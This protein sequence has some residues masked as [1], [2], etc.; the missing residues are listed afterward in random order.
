MT[1]SLPEDKRI[2]ILEHLRKFFNKQSCKI[3]DFARLIGT[4]NSICRT[5]AYGFVYIR[6]FER[7]KF[8]ACIDSNNDY[9]VRMMLPTSLQ[10]DFRWWLHRLR[11]PPIE[12]PLL[13]R[14]FSHVIFSDASPSG[15]GASMG[16]K[17]T[18]GWWSDQDRDEHINFLELKAVEYAL[19]SFGIDTS[20]FSTHTT[21][22]ASFSAAA[23]RGISIEDIRKTAG[24]S[25][26]SSTFANFYN[27]PV[28]PSTD[29]ARTII[30]NF[31]LRLHFVLYLV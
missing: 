10:P 15:W 2:V 3:R 5:V 12:R 26:N 6:D 25:P 30:L 31:Y 8:L 14:K 1:I 9:D 29:V 21:R 7:K 16:R 11:S 4:L 22:R 19:R 17:Q 27:R 23:R 28:M 20:I 13:R 24:W 18:H